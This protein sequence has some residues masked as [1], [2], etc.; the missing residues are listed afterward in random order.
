MLAGIVTDPGTAIGLEALGT[1][2]AT[3]PELAAE[4]E[5]AATAGAIVEVSFDLSEM[6]ELIWRMQ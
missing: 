3:V 1:D 2:A 5:S 4:V 6:D